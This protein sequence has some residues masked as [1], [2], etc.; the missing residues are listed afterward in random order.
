[1]LVDR[2]CQTQDNKLCWKGSMVPYSYHRILTCNAF[3]QQ[4]IK[5][6][7]KIAGSKAPVVI[8]GESGTGKELYA[9]YIHDHSGRN[10]KYVKMNCANLTETLFESE[11]FGYAPGAFTGALPAGKKGF[12]ELANEGTL[13]L[14]EISELQLNLQPKLLRVLQ[15]NCFMKLGAYN[16]IP[17]D[18][19]LIVASNK[20]LKNLLRHEQ[21]RK[22]L[23]Y[24]LN[25]VPINLIPLRERKE[26]IIL[27]SFY[28]LN[29][30]NATYA[31][32]K[33]M[34]KELME[35]F[36]DYPWP[37]N[38]RELRNTIER[39][40]LL[41]DSD[42]LADTSILDATYIS[43]PVFPITDSNI[44]QITPIRVRAMDTDRKQLSLREMVQEY[45]IFIIKEY[46]KETG[47]LRKAAKRLKT[48]PSVLSRKLN[49]KR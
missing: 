28:F 48:S 40:V 8:C 1:M 10:G 11:M 37:G 44:D 30:F 3:M 31:T 39:I 14:D 5:K 34:S 36:I 15:E 20:N 13:F 41:S 25:V 12:F 49:N 43:E 45:E 32:N 42:I 17:I 35:A 16:E 38:V 19:R 2:Y 47:S 6:I 22:D 46:V 7:D 18:V 29:E 24:R 21:F 4:Q 27:L 23:F 33:C 9:E 26:D